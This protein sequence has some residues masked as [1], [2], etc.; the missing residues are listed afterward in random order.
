MTL[1][2]EC[3]FRQLQQ[4]FNLLKMNNIKQ[5]VLYFNNKSTA[6]VI[7]TSIHIIKIKD[8]YIYYTTSCRFIIKNTL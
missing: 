6:I 1:F 7:V 8:S 3:L 4:Y 2:L 5:T